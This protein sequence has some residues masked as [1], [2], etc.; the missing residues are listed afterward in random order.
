MKSQAKALRANAAPDFCLEDGFNGPVCGLDEVGRGPLAGPVVAACVHIPEDSRTLPFVPR[1]RDSKKLSTIKLGELNTLIRQHCLWSIAEIGPEEIDEI[2]ILQASL[3]A[4]RLAC[5]GA[6]QTFA[7]AL[8]DG[9]RTPHALPC[10]ASAIIG[11]DARSISI[12]AASIIAK[13][14]R[15]ALMRE[16]HAQH[17]YYGW[18]R[19]AGYPTAEHREAIM[20][21]GITRHHRRS[22]GPVRG[23]IIQNL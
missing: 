1:I 23:Y 21:H 14:H 17:P 20:R 8:V 19:N 15:D 4:M 5:A 22:F 18:D 2:N 3:K 11:G 7:H 12:A 13:A 9:N 16:L 6:G 10:P